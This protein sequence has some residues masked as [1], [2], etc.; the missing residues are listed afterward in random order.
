MPDIL[1]M[2]VLVVTSQCF[3]MTCSAMDDWIQ[4]KLAARMTP[5]KEN[6]SIKSLVF[7]LYFDRLLASTWLVQINDLAKT[8][9]I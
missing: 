6:F 4:A 5:G 9:E 7:C 3:I 2:K 8:S 1:G